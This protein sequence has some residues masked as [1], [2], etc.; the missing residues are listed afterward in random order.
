[1]DLVAT[2]AMSIQIP[3]TLYLIH[4]SVNLNLIRFHDLL[5]SGTNVTKAHIDSSFLNTRISCFPRGFKQW[6]IHRV[7]CH[8]KSTINYISINMGA[9]IQF[10]HIIILKYS[11]VP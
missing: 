1:M 8:S 9:K 10:H 11:L 5:Y 7:E 3:Y 6:I 2:N 4:L